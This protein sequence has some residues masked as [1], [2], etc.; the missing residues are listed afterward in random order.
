[1][2]SVNRLRARKSPFRANCWIMDSGAFSE[3]SR[4]GHYRYPPEEYV[5]QIE[6]WRECGSLIGAVTQDYMCEDFILHKTC[7]SLYEHQ[8]RTIERYVAIASQVSPGVYIMPVLQGFAPDSY[9]DHIRMYGALLGVGAWVGVGSVCRRNGTPDAIEDVL[10]AIKTCRPDLR[11]HGFGIKL[12]ALERATVRELLYSAD[13]LAWS[14]H[15]SFD[16]EQNDPRHAL[17]YAA[18]VEQLIK[19]PTFIQHQLFNWWIS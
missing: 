5:E 15:A 10:L 13:S 16:D 17:E 12:T 14:Y 18:E 2:V 4:F 3:L 9:V 11:L 8:V 1:M 19:V 6:R 7:L